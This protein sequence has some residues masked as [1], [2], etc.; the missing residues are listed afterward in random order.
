M[1]RDHSSNPNA[2]INSYTFGTLTLSFKGLGVPFL[3]DKAKQ[4]I[5]AMD[6]AQAT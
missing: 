3:S 1:H 5:A 2:P 6:E 4:T